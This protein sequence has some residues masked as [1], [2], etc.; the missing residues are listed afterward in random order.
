[1]KG[2]AK[3]SSF[4][5]ALSSH[6]FILLPMWVLFRRISFPGEFLLSSIQTESSLR[7]SSRQSQI[8]WHLSHG[9][10]HRLNTRITALPTWGGRVHSGYSTCSRAAVS[11]RDDLPFR[12]HLA[13]SEDIFDCHLVVTTVGREVLRIRGAAEHPKVTECPPQK[14]Q[15][16]NY[17]APNVNSTKCYSRVG[18]PG[19]VSWL[20]YYWCLRHVANSPFNAYHIINA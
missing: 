9:R 4:S 17:L 20:F 11:T 7:S 2:P 18:M 19:F 13:M 15:Q 12:G 1:M 16:K 14:K 6:A 8:E 3:L 5:P 10:T